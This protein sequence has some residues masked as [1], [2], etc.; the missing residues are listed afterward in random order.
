MADRRRMS[1][2]EKRARQQLQ[3][4]RLETLKAV[5]ALGK[6]YPNSAKGE[7]ILK[8]HQHRVSQIIQQG[9]KPGNFA[10]SIHPGQPVRFA[11]G[12]SSVPLTT[13]QTYWVSSFSGQEALLVSSGEQDCFLSGGRL[14][15]RL[16]HGRSRFPFSGQS[17]FPPSCLSP[18]FSSSR[19]LDCSRI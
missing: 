19:Y 5:Q 17:Q 4:L 13:G 3:A 16:W 6:S 10:R 11:V 2:P 7:E 15:F 8:T 18:L 1:P 9:R 12:H 14:L